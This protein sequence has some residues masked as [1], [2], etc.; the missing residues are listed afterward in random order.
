LIEIRNL[1]KRFGSKVAVNNLTFNVEKG[2]ILGFL[3]PNGAGKT[4]TMR[5]LT[6]FMPATEGHAIVCGFDVFEKPQEVKKRVGYLPETP[7]LY[8]DM[9]VEEYLEFIASIKGINRRDKKLR[10]GQIIEQLTLQEVRHLIISK[11]SK[12]FRQRVG[13][14]QALIHKPEVL[15]LDE[16]TSGLDPLQ[17]VEVRKLITDLAEEHTIILSTHILPEVSMT[18]QRVIIINR[19][20][21]VAV[22]APD[23]LKN[24]LTSEDR[25]R[26]EIGG[27]AS[28]VYAALAQLKGAGTVSMDERALGQEPDRTVFHV[29]SAPEGD[30]RDQLL[31]LLVERGWKLYELRSEGMSLE[32]IFIRLTTR[33]ER[34]ERFD[35]K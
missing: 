32:E 9:T 21:V 24:R 17:V 7:P 18:C 27:P 8:R 5:M 26:L 16:P 23:R 4:T 11:L 6:G 12:G 29:D 10:I 2:E 22:D 1:T 14:A 31:P 30:M 19:G 28:E 34:E 3:G 20:R 25:L 35:S 15:I 33:D 13:L